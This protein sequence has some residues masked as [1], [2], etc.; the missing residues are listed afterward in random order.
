MLAG[1]SPRTTFLEAARAVCDA[2]LGEELGSEAVGR[3]VRRAFD[4][5]QTRP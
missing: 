3:I 5:E 2:L 4:F 1:F